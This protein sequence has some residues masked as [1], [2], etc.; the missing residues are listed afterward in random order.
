MATNELVV[1]DPRAAALA[2]TETYLDPMQEL[3]MQ[4]VRTG[5]LD[6]LAKLMDLAAIAQFCPQRAPCSRDGIWST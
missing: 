1:T 6:R 5:D 3:Q 2:Q 4:I